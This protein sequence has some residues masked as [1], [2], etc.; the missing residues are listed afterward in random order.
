MNQ[1]SLLLLRSSQ[2]QRQ[3]L[4]R[5]SRRNIGAALIAQLTFALMAETNSALQ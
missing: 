5:S 4:L 3:P 1:L 2:L